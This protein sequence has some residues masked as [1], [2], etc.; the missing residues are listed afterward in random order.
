[1]TV[2]QTS[3]ITRQRDM[4]RLGLW[5]GETLCQRLAYWI[6]STPDH[7]AVID[8][9]NREALT[10]TAPQRLSYLQL[11]GL[12]DIFANA[13]LDLG[14]ER[15]DRCMVQLPNVVEL[16]ALYCAASKLGVVISPIP[17]QYG[18]HEVTTL[19]A[20]LQ[21]KAFL[22]A[23]SLNGGSLADVGLSILP[24]R[25][26]LA[27][28]D[29]FVL[30]AVAGHSSALRQRIDAYQSRYPLDANNIL[31]VCWTSGTT[32]TP[33][34]VPRS[35]NMWLASADMT[36][37]GCDYR[38]GETLLNPFP[39]VN[40]SALGGFVFPG[41]DRGCRIVLHHPLDLGVYLSQI[42]HEA[43]QFTIAPPALLNKLALE[44]ELWARFDFQHLR[45]IGSGSA[46]L[47]PAMIETFEQR[48][49]IS[50]YNIYGSNEGIA[51]IASPKTTPDREARAS[52]FRLSESAQARGF[53]SRVIDVETGEP[54]QEIG[55][56]GEL[57]FSGPTVFDGYLDHDG[58]GVFCANGDFRTGDV[59]EIS[60]ADGLSYRI[61]GRC[62]ELINR[63][64]M[65]ISP[66]ELDLLLEAFPGLAEAA[67]CADPD[68]VLGERICACIV[69]QPEVTPPTLDE[70]IAYLRA[71]D[72]AVFKLPE[73][74]LVLDALPRNPLGKVLR[75][76]LTAQLQ[77]TAC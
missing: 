29:S 22:A 66:V 41:I 35:H 18:H 73:R 34:G 19:G 53:S 8:P 47:S 7:I 23:A 71:K 36:A 58:A 68:P 74:L 16:M 55:A 46:P 11:N 65:K 28:D 12:A 2:W 69:C 5:R 75:H 38:D 17:V 51:L 56:Q 44:P 10:G 31:T 37:Q 25:Q 42:Q 24:A 20:V 43:V 57:C 49:G 14:L 52:L 59:V 9:A 6:E 30:E 4:H 3:P 77:G 32:G 48:Y 61:A 15:G 54:V 60:S 72:I 64:G 26:V 45:G 39:M 33:K 40:M 27:V 13:L 62:K 67:V 50:I 21:P 1:M 70:I 76:E 63:G